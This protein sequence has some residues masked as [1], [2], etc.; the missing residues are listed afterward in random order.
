MKLLGNISS[1]TVHFLFLSLLFACALAPRAADAITAAGTWIG[2]GDSTQNA[3]DG[4]VQAIVSF[5]G[6]LYVAGTFTHVGS[7]AA[8]HIAR[9]DGATWSSL[10]TDSQNGTDGAISALAVNGTDLYVAGDFENDRRLS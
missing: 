10:G 6:N 4:A 3:P 7:I 1:R 8:N 9:W 2:F 5:G